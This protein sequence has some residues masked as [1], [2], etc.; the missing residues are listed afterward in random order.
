MF[1]SLSRELSHRQRVQQA[2]ADAAKKLV[3]RATTLSSQTT[4][5]RAGSVHLVE[6][7][8][9][10]FLLDIQKHSMAS[11]RARGTAGR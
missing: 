2:A 10:F 11:K 5:Q 4:G 1:Y 6:Q 3:E 9:R 7:L 8:C